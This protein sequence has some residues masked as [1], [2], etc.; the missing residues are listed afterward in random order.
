MHCTEGALW[1]KM[2]A[3]VRKASTLGGGG[4]VWQRDCRRGQHRE[5]FGQRRADRSAAL[6][7]CQKPLVKG[8][9]WISAGLA[10]KELWSKLVATAGWRSGC[11][12]TSRALPAYSSV[13]SATWRKTGRLPSSG[14]SA[15]HRLFQAR[16]PSRQRKEVRIALD[17]MALGQTRLDGVPFGARFDLLDGLKCLCLLARAGNALHLE[18]R[19]QSCRRQRGE[20]AVAE[21]RWRVRLADLQE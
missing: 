13:T 1:P 4:F 17:R 2:A 14:V 3:R 5:S 12:R 15:T 21:S 20:Y 16:S 18:R 8:Q 7:V 10:T 19:R 9:G 6:I 11:N